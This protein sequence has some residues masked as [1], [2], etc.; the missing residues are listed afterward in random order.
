VLVAAGSAVLSV[1]KSEALS[2][3]TDGIS[4]L[5]GDT[6]TDRARTARIDALESRA[7]GG[8]AS[9]VVA[10]CYEAFEPRRGLAGDLRSPVDGKRSPESVRADALSALRKY[11]AK[12]GGLPSGAEQWSAKL[13]N[14]PILPQPSASFVT[15]VRD[16][17][18]EG[19]AQGVQRSARDEIAERA[20]SALAKARPYIIGVAAIVGVVVLVK[21]LKR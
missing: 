3:V 19:I 20:D 7:L 21:L 14:A 1:A 17:A 18:V 5:F 9:A 2:S 8:D 4:G 15:S 13:G 10:L 12:F 6:K 11:V 16:A